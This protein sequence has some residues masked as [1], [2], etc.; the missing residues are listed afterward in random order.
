MNLKSALPNGQLYYFRAQLEIFGTE[1][2]SLNMMLAEHSDGEGVI[3][4]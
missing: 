3:M 1:D 4:C 2:G